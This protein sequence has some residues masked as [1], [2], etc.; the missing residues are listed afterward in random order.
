MTSRSLPLSDNLPRPVPL[1]T[2]LTVLLGSFYVRFGWL[3]LAIGLVTGWTFARHADYSAP[4][5]AVLARDTANGVVVEVSETR[6]TEGGNEEESG[7]RIFRVRYTFVAQGSAWEGVSYTSWDPPTPG[8]RVTVEYLRLDARLSRIRGMRRAWFGP[9]AAVGLVFPLIGAGLL[10]HG[11]GQGMQGCQLLR[12]GR[13]SRARLRDSR[14]TNVTINNR[15]V[16]ALTFEFRACD[17][18]D[19][20]I[21]AKSHE[22]ERLEDEPEEL[23]LYDPADPEY[24]VMLDGLPGS[25]ALSQSGVVLPSPWATT[26]WALAVPLLSLIA[27]GVF[28]ALV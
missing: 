20:Q 11:L 21:V 18:M 17:G 15:P 4:L 22:P 2:L 24:A 5:F 28:L 27:A 10:L 1:R 23:V 9:S 25:P 19:Y 3:M 14:P 13:L 26:V 12:K 16:M 8:Q 6:A 7:R